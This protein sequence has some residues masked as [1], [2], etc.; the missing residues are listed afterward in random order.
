MPKRAELP[1]SDVTRLFI[2]PNKRL[3]RR[4]VLALSSRKLKSSNSL[5]LSRGADP[6]SFVKSTRISNTH[7]GNC[8]LAVVMSKK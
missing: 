1:L 7:D 8:A 6:T 2:L 3:S 5:V 4:F